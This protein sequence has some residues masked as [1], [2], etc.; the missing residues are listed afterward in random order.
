MKRLVGAAVLATMCWAGLGQAKTY[1]GSEAAALRCAAILSVV[2]SAA[3]Q[4]GIIPPKEV[5]VFHIASALIMT[6]YVS[7]NPR[8]KQKAL[9]KVMQRYTVNQHINDFRTKARTCLRQFPF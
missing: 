4:A 5:Q 1:E 7:G 6:R 9:A 2:P 8:Q 3:A